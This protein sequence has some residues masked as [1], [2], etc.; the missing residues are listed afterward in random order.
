MIANGECLSV[1]RFATRSQ[2]FIDAYQK[3]L[4]G[5]QAAWAM[6]KYHGHCVLPESIWLEFDKAH[7]SPTHSDG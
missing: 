7:L 4:T 3:G 2:Q 5:Q 6:S 1:R